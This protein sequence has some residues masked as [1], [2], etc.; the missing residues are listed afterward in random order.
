MR[1]GAI[2][3]NRT[4]LTRFRTEKKKNSA[5]TLRILNTKLKICYQL[6]SFADLKKVL[7]LG[8]H[9]SERNIINGW[10][11]VLRIDRVLLILSL[12]LYD[13]VYT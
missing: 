5:S 11:L 10:V 13:D 12:W 8:H 4:T 7:S 6:S 3:N 9:G 2:I 1:K